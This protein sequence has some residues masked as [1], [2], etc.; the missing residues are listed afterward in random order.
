MKK[1]LFTLSLLLG[2]LLLVVSV[3]LFLWQY[4]AARS[5]AEDGRTLATRLEAMLPQRSQ[6]DETRQP[7]A[8][9]PVLQLDGAD[10]VAIL[11]V[12]GQS[13]PVADGWPG[14]LMTCPA[15]FAGTAYG[16]GL[17]IGGAQPQFDFCSQVEVGEQLLVTDMTGAQFAYTEGTVER[18]D[19]AQGRWLTEGY[20]LTLFCQ[21]SYG[22]Q[23]IAV[24]CDR[25]PLPGTP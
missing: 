8:Q 5:G 16:Q 11:E 1:R 6:G 25:C 3:G 17:V 20:D 23:Y 13:F 2:L 10:Y 12:R 21:D 4:F 9:M 15:R 19:S 22:M 14:D 18:A 24:R 7:D